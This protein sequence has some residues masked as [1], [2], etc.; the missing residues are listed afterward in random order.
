MSGEQFVNPEETHGET[1][2]LM[3]VVAER[4]RL[5]SIIAGTGGLISPSM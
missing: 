2:T 3:A 5:E 4:E 1:A